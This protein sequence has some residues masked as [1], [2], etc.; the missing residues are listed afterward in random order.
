MVT[1][2]FA[3]ALNR[4][5]SKPCIAMSGWDSRVSSATRPTHILAAGKTTSPL[6]LSTISVF[7]FNT[8]TA[9]HQ[10]QMSDTESRWL[11]AKRVSV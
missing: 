4:P 10:W 7:W 9:A 11:T 6:P 3:N 1:Y 8:H 2:A 5:D